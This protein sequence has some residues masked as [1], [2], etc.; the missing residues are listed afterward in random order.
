VIYT[1]RATHIPAKFL[2]IKSARQDQI[3]FEPYGRISIILA[4]HGDILTGI[5]NFSVV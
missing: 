2:C 5:H 3:A 1:P 4:T